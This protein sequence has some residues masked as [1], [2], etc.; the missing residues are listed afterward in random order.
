MSFNRDIAPIVDKHCVACHRPGGIGPFS[1]ISYTEVRSHASQIATVTKQRYMPPW[2]PQAGY[3]NFADERRLNDEE[4]RLLAAWA[5]TGAPEGPPATRPT[6][7]RFKDGWQLGTP[8]LIL[9]MPE[10]YIIPPDGT[11]VFRNFVLPTDLTGTKYITA[12]ELR[13]DNTRVVH[14]AN[15]VL[16]RAR[17]LRQRD[18]QDGQPGFPGM[19]ILTE[20]APGDFDPDSHFPLLETRHTFFALSLMR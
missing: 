17:S 15:I 5:N 14:H 8:D 18:K 4:I 16:D 2:P 12:A 20:A 10:P 9:R 19:D 13:M 1:L 6:P 11:D 3:G 7:P